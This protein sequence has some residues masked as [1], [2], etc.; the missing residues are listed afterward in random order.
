M[1]EAGTSAFGEMT[2]A[3]YLAANSVEMAPVD[4]DG[5]E[6][7]GIAASTPAGW[8]AAPT[9]QFPGTTEVLV[10]PGMIENGFAPNA[11]LLVGRLSARVDPEAVL[12]CSFTD[13]R[14]L[15]GW[16]E[17][18]VSFDDLGPWPSRFVW[19]TFVSDQ[20]NLAVTTR[21]AVVGADEQYLVQ[22]TVTVATD[23]MDK[24]AFDVAA[25]NDGLFVGGR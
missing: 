2:V 15:P 22:L 18:E 23:Q 13:A 3:Q 1:S 17:L 9:D 6:Q 10:E 11:V 8:Q 16:S 21:Y 12:N 14:L 20:L 24:L 19:G 25:I 7:L 5:A 4:R